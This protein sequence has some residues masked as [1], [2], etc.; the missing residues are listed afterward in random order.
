MHLSKF[1]QNTFFQAV[2][3]STLW[4]SPV[5]Q[6]LGLGAEARAA[7]NPFRVEVEPPSG[8]VPGAS[9][10]V[11]VVVVVPEG[12]HV[13]RDMMHVEVVE[14]GGLRWGAPS[15]P[16]GL[17]TPD[18]ANPSAQREVYDTNV[19]VELPVTAG[20][21]SGAIAARVEVKYQ[22]CKKSL[23]YMPATELLDVVVPVGAAPGGAAPQKGQRGAALTEPPGWRE[24]A[25]VSGGHGGAP[26]AAP[27]WA[28]LPA[29]AVVEKIDAEG[30]KH[31]VVARLVADASPAAPGQPLRLGVHLSMDP[32]WH[33]YWKTP[34]DIG[35]PTEIEWTLPP[36]WTASPFAF[37][38]PHR[39]DVSGIIS[40][41][42][43][44]EVMFFTELQVP[45]GTPAGELRLGAAVRWLVCESMC[46][47]GEAKLELPLVVG[48]AAAP[49]PWAPLFERSAAAL[50]AAEAPGL[51]LESALSV[52]AVS[53]AAPFQAVLHLLPAE[54]SLEAKVEAG[55]WPAFTPIVPPSV[56]LT[57]VKLE[58]SEAGGLIVRM[59]G[60]G[61]EVDPLPTADRI[62]GLFQVSVNGAPQQ[63]ELTVPLPF[64]ATGAPA[65]SPLMALRG[66]PLVS[67]PGSGSPSPAAGPEASGPAPAT[68]AA[69]PSALP[70]A[71]DL[72]FWS[73]LLLAFL[74]GGI[75]NV[76]PCV[77]PV[78]T[79]KLFSLVEQR[80][81][82]ARRRS[83]AGLV[84]GAGVVAS[85]LALALVVI[86]AKSIF[87]E[88]L[89][90]GSQFQYPEY[91]LA[92]TVI[93][94]VFGLSLFGVF[95]VPAFG[96]NEA[97]QASQKGGMTGYFLTGV[98]TTLLATPCS[99]PLLGSAMGFAFTL[100]PS[101]VL[102]FF[103]V[104][105]LGLAFP[106]VVVAMVPALMRFM[107]RPGAWMETFKH[108][109]GFS[110]MATTVWLLDVMG[111]LLG[112]DGLTGVTTFL[113]GLGVA[114]WAVG[115][116]GGPIE[117]TGRQ[118]GVMFGA[119]GL[120]AALGVKV[121]DFSPPP[122]PA[123]L[124]A[125]PAAGSLDYSEGVPWVAFTEANV[126]K[127]AGEVVFID[128]TA[129]W[130][131]TCKVN[132]K[133]VI[134]QPGTREGMAAL[135]VVP[136]KADWTR[137]D[138]TIS[139]WLQRYGRAGVPFYL[140]LPKDRSKPA[141]PLGEV[142]TQQ[143]LLDAL[144]AAGT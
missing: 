40:Y 26:A 116:F 73:M 6:A 70:P 102:L 55:S 140:I 121:L 89:G 37:P 41:G 143:G 3:G 95:E 24:G 36:G 136:L 87:G 117:S 133:T 21:A 51:R 100:P 15:F 129:D 60:E 5:G 128:F 77:L 122:E 126:E 38:I 16:V 76:M 74:G 23:C 64:A 54:G 69:A 106:F 45:P 10:V 33:T 82:D 52:T 118:L 131:L 135:G 119:V 39:Y 7:A 35:L 48:A 86:G 43:E 81:M 2:L 1:L 84:Y 123:A 104:A 19:V 115:R 59:E 27:S 94:F 130:C 28:G 12:F 31:P 144:R 112:R 53:P 109:M 67:P 93:V 80:D 132:E 92:L 11:R 134:E 91:V 99:A 9:G 75:L 71:E 47:P 103:A 97:A 13:Y 46:I 42:Y 125:A 96:A 56:F 111:G 14:A 30:K 114:A 25:M 101:G 138:P 137:R 90:W 68:A 65:E 8:L 127:Y 85:F 72:G 29:T 57:A 49:S 83:Q 139:A 78:L 120:S 142:L 88:S 44:N 32:G 113:L 22:G 66:S 107:P 62:G 34:G 98:F 20:A 108:L 79:L 18:P 50:P 124:S 110:L 58:R 105:G 63:V 61:L 17:Q 4:L 141:I